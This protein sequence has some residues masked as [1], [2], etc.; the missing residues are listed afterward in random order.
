MNLPA[1]R[2]RCPRAAYSAAMPSTHAS[3]RRSEAVARRALLRDL[4]YDVA[5]DLAAGER[6]FGSRTTIRFASGAGRTFAEVRPVELRSAY[7]DGE[8]VD[9]GAW[10]DGRLALT[11]GAGEHELVVEALMPFRTDGEGLHRSVDPADGRHYVYG[12]SFL[13]AAPTVFA[14][15]D[16]PDLKA[17]YT[18]HV[19]AP[20]DWIVVGNAPG[21][22]SPGV[23][24]VMPGL[25][26]PGLVRP[27]LVRPGVVM[28]GLVRPVVPRPG[29]PR[30][31]VPSPEVPRLGLARPGVLVAPP[32]KAGTGG[33]LI[34]NCDKPCDSAPISS[35]GKSL[36]TA[37]CLNS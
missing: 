11:L 10:R 33:R 1:T 32:L 35:P 21:A 3:L 5:L 28:P 17:P 8:R 4:E 9:A 15:F 36:I 24:G 25:V 19:R 13:D 22:V 7:L 26:R 16:Q 18:F 37:A 27:G 12:M 23:M 14:C 29:V 30:P 31:G 2:A 6:T 20:E 34:P